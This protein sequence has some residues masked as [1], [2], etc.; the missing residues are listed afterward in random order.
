MPCVGYRAPA[1]Y[2]GV[3]VTT[4]SRKTALE[5]VPCGHSLTELKESLDSALRWLWCLILV[6][7]FQPRRFC[8]SKW[9]CRAGS[10][11]GVS[12]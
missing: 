4:H 3:G 2:P 8:D 6:G 5:Q 1:G 10:A 12:C 9:Y 11:Q 7:P